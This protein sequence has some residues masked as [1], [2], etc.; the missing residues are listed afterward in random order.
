MLEASGAALV[1]SSLVSDTETRTAGS[2]GTP[3]D[4][5][6]GGAFTAPSPRRHG[7]T[8]ARGQWP[9]ESFNLQASELRL[10]YHFPPIA[11]PSAPTL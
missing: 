9:K 10:E 8:V 3:L 7:D 2:A 11:L 5:S 4:G 1:S 6:A